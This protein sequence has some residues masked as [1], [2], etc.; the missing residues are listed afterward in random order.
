MTFDVKLETI[1]NNIFKQGISRQKISTRVNLEVNQEVFTKILEYLQN[2]EL[3]TSVFDNK[4]MCSGNGY[5]RI[6]LKS[7][8]EWLIYNSEKIGV[9]E[10]IEQF[11]DYLEHDYTPA[12]AIL[13]VS[14][15]E[16]SERIQLSDTI[17]LIPFVDLPPSKAK[18]ALY[19][20]LLKENPGID[21][22]NPIFSTYNP[23]KMAL[24]KKVQLKPKVYD[25]DIAETNTLTIEYNDLYET[26]MFLTL[27]SNSTP[28]SA[29]AW[30]ELD[31]GVPCKNMSGVGFSYPSPEIIVRMDIP[32]HKYEWEK[33]QSTYHQFIKLDSRTKDLLSIVLQRLNQA[34]RR[35]RVEDRAIDQGIA[36][37]VLLLN[38]KEHKTGISWKLRNRVA[39][40]LE[41]EIGAR[42]KLCEFF[43]AFYK[44]RSKA[45]HVGKINNTINVANRGM[46]KI[47]DLLEES[48]QLCVKAIKKIILNGGFLNW[49]KVKLGI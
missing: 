20:S 23:P 31:E 38:D 15:I 4:M 29:G 21:L 28:V 35:Q 1:L 6:Q 42:E 2:N 33:I 18:N 3:I 26:C 36:F 27:H 16:P 11:N 40:I 14:G 46:M 41:E 39:Y 24:V 45:T 9:Q 49:D 7:L 22:L 8:A 10:T 37:E 19:P 48:D 47:H 25:N 13:A 17:E 32:F 34:R 43:K 44:C 30:V 12:I 5:S